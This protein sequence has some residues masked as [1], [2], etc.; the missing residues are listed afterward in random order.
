MEGA[1]KSKEVKI[2]GEG[3]KFCSFLGELGWSIMNG[4][5]E[6]D[7]EGELIYTG[8]RG[9][10]V[11]DYVVGNGE[12]RERVRKMKVEDR[13]DSDHQPISVEGGGKRGEKRGSKKK[14]K[15]RGIWTEEGKGKFRELFGGK[16]EEWEEVDEGWKKLT[17]R[18]EESLEKVEAGMKREGGKSWWDGECKERKE[19]ERGIENMEG[20]R[21]R[22]KD[23]K[24]GGKSIE[25]YVRKRSKRRGK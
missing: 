21:G 9:E 18:V 4:D 13:I 15:R 2:N 10:S 22:G 3:R 19:R 14:G 6:G 24:K 16:D 17:E 7:E 20:R 8:R 11:I 25:E 5:M 12:T 23:R 1:R